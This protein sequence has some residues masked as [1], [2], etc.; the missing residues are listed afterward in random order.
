MLEKIIPSPD[1]SIGKK[2]DYLQREYREMLKR[3]YRFSNAKQRM[4]ELNEQKKKRSSEGLFKEYDRLMSEIKKET[5][6]INLPTFSFKSYMSMKERDI[7]Y[8]DLEEGFYGGEWGRYNRKN[9]EHLMYPVFQE[10]DGVV[11]Y[12]KKWRWQGMSV[13]TYGE[14]EEKSLGIYEEVWIPQ[15]EVKLT[16]KYTGENVTIDDFQLGE[17]M[18]SKITD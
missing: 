3:L 6:P 4:E 14:Y 5:L 16:Y 10:F 1:L 11:G 18:K 2:P 12:I 15:E 8:L 17:S 9:E 13:I 7:I